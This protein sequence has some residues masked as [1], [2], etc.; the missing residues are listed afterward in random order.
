MQNI[1]VVPEGDSGLLIQFEQ[2]ISP[3]I[4]QRIAA[5]VKLIR[6][7]QISG[8]I[9]MIPTYCSCSLTIIRR[10]FPIRSFTIASNPSSRWIL[11]P[12]PSRKRYMRSRPV[13]VVNTA[14]ILKTL[15]SMPAFLKKK[16]SGFIPVLITS[17]TCSAS[18]RASPISGVSTNV[19]TH[20]VS[21]THVSSSRPVL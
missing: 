16:S 4:N 15:R 7:Q 6:A 9:D 2:V 19:S 20:R 1:K 14:R 17:S 18:C 21:Q 3:A 13:M 8:I 5:I 10:L 11:R 12:N